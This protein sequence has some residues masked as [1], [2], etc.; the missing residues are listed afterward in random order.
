MKIKIGI[1]IICSFF[2][3]F[4]SYSQSIQLHLDYEKVLNEFFQN[5]SIDSLGY[6]NDVTFEKRPNGWA[7]GIKNYS[8][9]T[10]TY[11]TSMYWEKA[12]NKF[13][14]LNLPKAEWN[15]DVASKVNQFLNN[16]GTFDYK[17]ILYYGYSGWEKEVMQ[18]LENK[19][20][21][22][23]NELYSLAKAYSNYASGLLTNNHGNN[24][25][26]ARFKLNDGFNCL[27]PEQL[28]LYLK[29]RKLGIE[30]YKKLSLQYP[31][32][33]TLVGKAQIKYSNEF[34]TAYH[35]LLMYQNQNEA[36]KMIVDNLYNDFFIALAKN[37]LISCPKNAVLFTN[38]D[39]DTY[40]LLYVQEKM[41]FRKDVLVVN[42]SLLA[43]LRYIHVMRTKYTEAEPLNLKISQTEFADK[44]KEVVY[45]TQISEDMPYVSLA[46][47]IESIR[48][49]LNRYGD[50]ANQYS[51]IMN[52]KF[53]IFMG[54]SNSKIDS[55]NFIYWKLNKNY[56]LRNELAIL[57]FLAQNQGKRPVCFVNSSPGFC[58]GLSEYVYRAG[59]V[60]CLENR[61][62]TLKDY[63]SANVN[64]KIS[65]NLVFNKFDWKGLNEIKNID[66]F[67]INFYKVMFNSIAAKLKTVN[68]FQDATKTLDYYYQ[69]FPIN[70]FPI[71]YYTVTFAELYLGCNK[72]EIGAEHLKLVIEWLKLSKDEE[73]KD[74]AR[75]QNYIYWLDQ[76]VTQYNLI[77]LQQEI[78]TLKKQ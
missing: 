67:S 59:M 37:Y 21:F 77:D 64:E 65:Y 14:K 72:T 22:N 25:S 24:D 73:L 66:L 50:D 4:M 63:H 6:V 43:D 41:G 46:E 74:K 16:Y 69:L 76:L 52:N 7:V 75:R 5:Y 32:F 44:S 1:S 45:I 18:S 38:G 26:L 29:F 42:F 39:N 47:I 2:F 61:K 56:L 70:K 57:D 53:K 11:V 8:F 51:M 54:K 78:E 68:R 10:P 19:P 12:T 31:D 35:D 71:N 33:E 49:S 34:I 58:L 60:Y 30:T 9:Q 20:L 28:S 15:A 3:S 40:P 27:T 13:L 48:D 55:L 36:R 62:D 17:N 23:A